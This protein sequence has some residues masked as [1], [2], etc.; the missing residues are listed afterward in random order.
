MK[1]L[2]FPVILLLSLAICLSASAVVNDRTNVCSYGAVPNDGLDD[3]TAINNAISA[4]RS[5]YFPAGTYNY[6]GSMTLPANT[7]YRLYGDGPDVSTIIFTGTNAGINGWSMGPNTLTVDGLTLGASSANCGTAITAKFSESGSSTKF[8]T[9]TIHNVQIIGYPRTGSGYWTNGIYL[10]KA[11]NSVIDKVEITGTLVTGG[12]PG[13]TQTGIVWESS[14]DYKTAGLQISNFEI[15]FAD[16]AVRTL[17]WVEGFYMTGFEVVLCGQHGVP[18]VDLTSFDP[19]NQKS[20]FHLLSGHIQTLEQ[21]IRL[22]NLSDVRISKVNFAH[23]ASDGKHDFTL[24]GTIVNIS[25]SADVVVSGCTFFGWPV[26]NE[27]G[28]LLDN[29]HGVRIAGNYFFHMQPANGSC[30]V[31]LANSDTARITDNLFSDVRNRYIDY[32][33]PFNTYYRGNN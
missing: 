12:S 15:K 19:N 13:G 21:G 7:S 5:I 9:A 20:S 24:D 6:A 1:T 8:H 2:L 26:A 18:A 33:P 25:N 23:A 10:Y 14:N 27:N 3:T 29:A 30:I 17:G 28:V 32:A 11:Q 31:I 16:T 4:G 22:L